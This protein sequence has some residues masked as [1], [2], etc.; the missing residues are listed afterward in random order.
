MNNKEKQSKY[1]LLM[2]KLDIATNEEFYFEAILIEYAILEDRTESILR[3]ADIK[4]P[5]GLQ[6]KIN[7][8]KENKIFEE[9]KI[10]KHLT[11]K[12]INSIE[13]WKNHRNIIIHDLVESSYDKKEIKDIALTGECLVKRFA[14]K[15]VLVN[16]YLENKKTK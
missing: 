4:V 5:K 11:D 7:T 6:K 2:K 8:I 15:S 16:K 9:E 1:A 3:H 14:N 10:K 12:L 13:I